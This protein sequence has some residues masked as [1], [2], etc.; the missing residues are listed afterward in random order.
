[1]E[2]FSVVFGIRLYLL[3]L[4]DCR[5]VAGGFRHL[6]TDLRFM[7]LCFCREYALRL[8]IVLLHC[9]VA[10]RIFIAHLHCD[11]LRLSLLAFLDAR[12]TM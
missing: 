1:M 4:I 10:L 6:I 8:R 7:Q 5:F 11:R 2:I 12:E 3:W 9:N